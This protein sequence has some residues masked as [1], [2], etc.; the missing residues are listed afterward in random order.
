MASLIVGAPVG[1]YSF[2]T[3][4]GGE[5]LSVTDSTWTDT[6]S[7]WVNPTRDASNPYA[8]FEGDFFAVDSSNIYNVLAV[9]SNSVDLVMVSPDSSDD[10]G[11]FVEI[12]PDDSAIVQAQSEFTTDTAESGYLRTGG[13]SAGA[14]GTELAS[15]G[16]VGFLTLCQ[17]AR[18]TLGFAAAKTV[19]FGVLAIASLGDQPEFAVWAGK[20]AVQSLA[21]AGASYYTAHKN[22]CL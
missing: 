10:A 14:S 21:L 6:P 20:Q 8:P 16:V 7:A 3:T 9:G 2:S 5:P 12:D 4:L 13:S 15:P 19:F 17:G 22:G 18:I 1:T 11:D